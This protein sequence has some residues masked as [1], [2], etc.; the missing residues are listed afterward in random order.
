MKVHSGTAT[1]FEIEE[2]NKLNDSMLELYKT[3]QEINNEL[4]NNNIAQNA[5]SEFI[6][7][8]GA[9][10]DSYLQE[11]ENKIIG[12][13]GVIEKA[14][15]SRQNSGKGF[16]S[17]FTNDLNMVNNWFSEISTL[18]KEAFESGDWGEDQLKRVAELLN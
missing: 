6:R 8:R 11:Y 17:S 16:S 7:N 3:L 9:F 18:R 5:Y 12:E 1:D 13:G 10:F 4:G 2:Y 14:K 15:Q